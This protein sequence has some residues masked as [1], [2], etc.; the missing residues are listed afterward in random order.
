MSMSDAIRSQVYAKIQDVVADDT[1]TITDDLT[2]IGSGRVLE[3]MS[4]V[5]LCLSLEDLAAELGFEFDWSSESAMSNSRSMFRTA[6]SLATE[7]QLQMER[8][9]Q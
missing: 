5:E 8:Q 3:S 4:L 9:Q 2:L 6:G 7:F 1:T